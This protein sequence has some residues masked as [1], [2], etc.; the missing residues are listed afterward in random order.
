MSV[1]HQRMDQ[2]QWIDDTCGAFDDALGP[3]AACCC[4]LSSMSYMLLYIYHGIPCPVG[5]TL[6]GMVARCLVQQDTAVS[7]CLEQ[8]YHLCDEI[9]CTS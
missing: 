2:K 8:N 9:T 4:Q 7:W 1:L 5:C 6:I 3:S